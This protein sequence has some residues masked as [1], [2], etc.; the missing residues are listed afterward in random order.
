MALN[1][2]TGTA[3]LGADA[4][5]RFTQDGTSIVSFNAAIDSGYGDKKVTTWIRFS[6][7]GKRGE[8]V[9]PYLTKSIK[10]GVSGE[11]TNRKWQD[12]EGQDRYSLEVRLNELDLPEKSNS[13]NVPAQKAP[14]SANSQKSKQQFD[15]LGDDIPF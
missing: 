5:Q 13:A 8:S 12:K 14:D 15:D 11:L 9:L 1:V 3:R 6:L 7:F 2:F 10:V 4:E